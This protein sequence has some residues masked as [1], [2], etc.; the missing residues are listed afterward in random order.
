[1]FYV[2]CHRRRSKKFQ[3]KEIENEETKIEEKKSRTE[4]GK[5]DD[6]GNV[7]NV[8][9]KESVD[10]VE[11]AVAEIE[12]EEKLANAKR[13]NKKR[14]FFKRPNRTKTDTKIDMNHILF[15]ASNSVEEEAED[16]DMESEDA[17][18]KE[19]NNKNHFI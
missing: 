8:S 10:E 13:K 6:V 7:S 18:C 11:T 4:A 5:N 12:K 9:T 16:S 17:E 3:K 1:M 19:Y 15:G 2:I 14:N